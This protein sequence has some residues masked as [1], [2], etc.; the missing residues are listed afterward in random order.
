MAFFDDSSVRV[1]RTRCEQK[2]QP[3]L[4]TDPSL[5]KYL[6]DMFSARDN[7]KKSH[8][9]TLSTTPAPRT[10]ARTTSCSWR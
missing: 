2:T 3:A 8:P 5:R 1:A 6:I 7:K 10:A 9:Q 4:A